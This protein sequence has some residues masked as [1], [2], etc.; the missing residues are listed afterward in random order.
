MERRELPEGWEW[1]RL[2]EIAEINPKFDKNSYSDELEVTFLPMRCVEECT[3]KIDCSLVRPFGEVK[4]GYTPIKE[5]DLLFAKITPCIENGKIA[6]AANLKNE[7]GFASTEFH[8][9][10]FHSDNDVNFFRYFLLQ[11][12]IRQDASR[13]M[14]GTAGQQRV[15]VIFLKR[16]QVPVPPLAVQ[17]RI[18]EIL[19]QVDALQRLRAQADAE[20]QTLLQSVFYEMFGDPVRNEKGWE[21]KRLGEITKVVVSYVGPINRYFCEKEHGVPLLNTT[22]IS[23]NGLIF[24]HIR[25]VTRDFHKKM[26]KSQLHPGDII[27]ARH[28]ES[29]S[30]TIIPDSLIEAQSINNIIIKKSHNLEED[31]ICYLLNLSINSQKILGLKTGTVQKVINTKQLSN[32]KIPIPPFFLQQQF[33][34]IVKEF[35]Q[36]KNVQIESKSEIEHLNRTL[37]SEA[38]TGE[39]IA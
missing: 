15:P 30:A 26:R 22:N 5:G 24:N 32:Y 23:L 16:L 27:V 8:T 9:I 18:V 39:L 28:G 36:I 1:K 37:M 6:I 4:S 19:H 17:R 20:T 2:E 11:D 34:N 25:Y 12:K 31:Y 35:S 3:G 29:G 14:T 38:F 7:I 21:M 13:S 33:A 10:R